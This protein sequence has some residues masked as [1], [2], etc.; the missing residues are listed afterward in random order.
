MMTLIKNGEPYI[1]THKCSPRESKGSLLTQ[2]RLRQFLV[3][4]LYES[5]CNC[6]SNIKKVNDSW[7]YDNKPSS[8]KR[9]PDLI[10]RMG[11]DTHDTWFYIMPKVED[12][13]LIDLSF[14]EEAANSHNI[15]PVLVVGDVWCYDTNGSHNIC[16]GSY[17]SK[18]ETISL[19]PHHNFPLTERL[20]QKQL[21]EKVAL[22]WQNIDADILEPYLDK[23]F[24][25][26][27]DAV[28]YEMSS[29][30]EYINYLKA[31]FERLKDG[32]NP[33]R[34]QM[35]RMEGSDDFVLLLHQG[36]YN[37]SLLL[38][39]KAHDGRITSM[40]MSEYRN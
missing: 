2:E 1:Y 28:F 5:F 40:R 21:V 24:H 37:Q 14:V 16:G 18:Y 30:H 8:L 9:K 39:I 3:D 25:Y 36:A 32:S 34:V 23:D 17:A 26:S 4:T 19:L 6:N 31:K 33:I 7:T 27:S 35:G 13:D 29:R 20:N 15:L 22:C 10:Y 38:T 11:G 12:R